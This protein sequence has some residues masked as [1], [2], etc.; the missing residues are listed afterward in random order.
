MH[1]PLEIAKN[2]VEVGIFKAKMSIFKM[3]LLG[4][5][6]GM[7]I[8]FA[9]IAS[10]TAGCSIEL[11]SVSKLAGALIFPSG[12]AMVL[13]AG[14]ELFTGNNLIILAV[15]EKKIT[16]LQML[17]NWLF[18]YI[19]N[20]L[21]TAFV[22]FMVVY[23]HTPDLFGGNLSA[24]IV[25]AGKARTDLSFM[26]G[27]FK[28]ILCNIL[29]CIAVWMSFAAKKVSGKLMTSYWPVLLFVLCGFEHSIADMYFGVA[30]LLT[31]SV[32]DISA[33][34][35]TWF[36]FLLG[37]LLPVTLGNIVGGAGIVGFGYWLSYLHRTPY[38]HNLE[39]KEQ[40]E[41]DIAEEY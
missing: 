30:A 28:G 7:F 24:A 41:I 26:D 17:R 25:N 16:V 2:Y 20:F 11:P 33:E 1:S 31:S 8:G 19:G 21:G 15:L 13:I 6:A 23:S 3:L 32:Y 40:T 10:T 27:F 37:N 35:L 18:V 34:G 39:E 4:F 29:V 5:F 12:M 38:S 14:S 9:G 22:A 36:H